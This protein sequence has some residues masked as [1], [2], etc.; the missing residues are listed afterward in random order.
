[1]TASEESDEVKTKFMVRELQL[2]PAQLEFTLDAI[3]AQNNFFRETN[4]PYSNFTQYTDGGLL[5]YSVEF[6]NYA[7]I[8]QIIATV[9]RLWKDNPE[10]SKE[11]QLEFEG[12]YKSVGKMVLEHQP[13]LS[14]PPRAP[15]EV[16]SEKQYRFI[17]KCYLKRGK[18]EVFE[19]VMKKYIKLRKRLKIQ[20]SF[21]T[22]Y[23]SFGA[24]LSVV[25]RPTGSPVDRR[26][27]G[28]DAPVRRPG[29]H[30]AGGTRPPPAGD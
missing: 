13:Q 17:E 20:D 1:M 8:D 14:F 18:K 10:V 30:Q 7:D 15:F 27:H 22:L 12:A 25:G 11:L 24:D 9:D 26:V 28:A 23:P 5:W 3:R 16:T 6:T 29:A 21:Y 4:F 2:T 19:D